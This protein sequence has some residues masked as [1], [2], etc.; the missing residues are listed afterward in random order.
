MNERSKF[1][2]II[3]KWYR[4]FEYLRRHRICS[5]ELTQIRSKLGYDTFD[6]LYRNKRKEELNQRSRATIVWGEVAE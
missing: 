2:L 5:C 4:R 6:W 3:R 1:S